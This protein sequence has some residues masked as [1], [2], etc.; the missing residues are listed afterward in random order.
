MNY[1]LRIDGVLGDSLDKDHKGW[2]AIDSLALDALLDGSGRFG[3]LSSVQFG[4]ASM[5]L[6]TA[7]QPALQNGTLLDAVTL[8]MVSTDG[9]RL[10]QIRL[11]DV[12][13][14]GLSSA[15]QNGDPGRLGVTLDART[16]S[17]IDYGLNAQG[18]AVRDAEFGWDA[19]LLRPVD[20]DTVDL[21]SGG[22]QL[23]S[24]GA[25]TQ[26]FVR[27][28]GVSGNA[29]HKAFS[30]WF[31][32]TGFDGPI[33]GGPGAQPDGAPL[34]LQLALGVGLAPILTRLAGGQELAAV[35]IH[36]INSLGT[37]VHEIRLNDV[38]ITGMDGL[39]ASGPE[40]RLQLDYGQVGQRFTGVDGKGLPLTPVSF[41]WDR[42]TE[43]AVNFAEL[44]EAVATASPS[45]MG[46]LGS[47]YFVRFNDLGGDSVDAKHKGWFD[48][49]DFDLS[50]VVPTLLSKGNLVANGKGMDFSPLTLDL[51]LGP[52]LATLLARAGDTG[53][54]GNLE[55][56]GIQ[57]LSGGGTLTPFTLR[58][59]GVSL[60][61]ADVGGP[62]A[63]ES[64]VLD[65]QQIGLIQRGYSAAGTLNTTNS[66]GWDFAQN[67]SIDATAVGTPTQGTA[68]PGDTGRLNT[69]YLRIDGIGGP[70]VDAD[71][72]GWFEL[73]DLDLRFERT[74]GG[75]PM[76]PGELQL[77]F[78]AGT[79]LPL[80]LSQ[81]T[82]GKSV[83]AVE[84]EGV[85]NGASGPV[86]LQQIR[87]Q[88]VLFSSVGE[89]SGNQ[90][91]FSL[92]YE[93]ISLDEDWLDGRG[94]VV[95]GTVYSYDLVNEKAG[96][97]ALPAASSGV[98]QY[99]HP[100]TMDHY[101]FIDGIDGGVRSKGLEGAFQLGDFALDLQ[102]LVSLGAGGATSGKPAF[103][104]LSLN[105]DLSQGLAPL[106]AQ[107]FG[108]GAPLGAARV[109]GVAHTSTASQTLYE[110]R[111]NQVTVQHLNERSD[112]FGDGLDLGF[113]SLGLSTWGLDA[114]G[115]RTAATTFGWDTVKNTELPFAALSQP[116]AP[117]LGALAGGGSR[118]FLKIDGVYGNVT[119][120]GHLGWFE[121][122]GFS[123][124]TDL[125]KG[126]PALGDVDLQLQAGSDF[127]ALLAPLLMGR[128]LDAVQIHGVR[129]LQLDGT[130]E[131][132]L[133]WRFNGVQFTHI[134]QSGTSGD[135]A[136]QTALSLNA[137]RFGVVALRYDNAGKPV[138][139]PLLF[140]YDSAA[141]QGVDPRN[142]ATPVIGTGVPFTAPVDS[143]TTPNATTENAV[144][145]SR[146][147]LDMSSAAAE[148]FELRTNP[149]NLFA[150]NATTGVVTVAGQIGAHL[151][152]QT[153]TLSI[154][155]IT[156]EGVVKTS[157]FGVFVGDVP[158]QTFFGGAG[159]DTQ[160]GGDL[161][162]LF[163]GGLG[164]DSFT[165]GS[166]NDSL[167]GTAG[168]DRL[169]GDAGDDLLDGG[170]GIDTAVF[171][172]TQS[173]TVSL[174]IAGPQDTGHGMDQLV[175]IENIVSAGSGDD[176]LTGNQLANTINAGA[177]NDTLVGG[178]GND[179]LLGGNGNDLLRG[180]AGNDT[181]DGG[182][183][184]D[185]AVYATDTAGVQVSLL[186]SG[187]EQFISSTQGLDTL[188]GIEHLTSG[189][190]HDRLTGNELD[191]QLSGGN[192]NDTLEGGAGNDTLIGGAGLD[193]AV[194]TGNAAVTVNLSIL[195]AQNTGH[196]MDTL[197]SIENLRS[198]NGND[199]LTGNGAANTI[200]AGVGSDT[201]NGGLG[202][203]VLWGEG[204]D[205]RLN[206]G[207]GND[208]LIGG[209]GRDTLV[210]GAG[211][212]LFRYLQA[213][214]IGLSGE[215]IAD[216]Q[217]GLDQIDLT[218]LGLS[219][220]VAS[221]SGTAGE[222]R[223]SAPL[224][225]QWLLQGDLNGD[226]VADFQL[227][228]LGV[229]L[230][231]AGDILI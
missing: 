162:D 195:V 117:V 189:S 192:G 92:A 75:G 23:L 21:A 52:A 171:V 223:L 218:A 35:Q 214:E 212:D 199:S 107:Q 226:A 188:I 209:L 160:A 29:T 123:L 68:A 12:S 136:P 40:Q 105:L 200:E 187:T 74:P 11:D 206:G 77:V 172:G 170:A 120:K 16:I 80:L 150:I 128:T 22:T 2:F 141:A 211:N 176:R 56:E 207:D 8:E 28:D 142:L 65:F 98:Q 81:L 231:S 58:L 87:L 33:P 138:N 108:G 198:G 96:S 37:L 230:V 61:Q 112:L 161:A 78:D 14:G 24:G 148:R 13:V 60:I 156:P 104:T 190:G 4:T 83:A 90:E 64:L 93:A 89:G 97:T 146:I 140:G 1:Y 43:R 178:A 42:E 167:Y 110:L 166:G 124:P 225:G 134:G 51:D 118:F 101:L 196:G 70:S 46:G 26:Y 122:D 109:L 219:A 48:L 63:P 175:G 180:D 91:R 174:A 131:L 88:D 168:N 44:Q 194:F 165:G 164:N 99:G 45:A 125:S 3:D 210:G 127:A 32:L 182:N 114:S 73:S 49:P 201:V 221:F 229:S 85:T 220:V 39:G 159:A 103:S 7:L 224:A 84:I 15:W 57:L 147:G 132:V 185:T 186:L 151:V 38:F 153:L 213:D 217:T 173:T 71:H 111:L 113:D 227:Q 82:S 145:G 27:F 203:D 177:G 50:A 135:A 152:G 76:D 158:G 155:A 102:S 72:K 54:I 86:T 59:G 25:G 193:T 6:L 62:G 10:Q 19:A 126:A 94:Q 184:Q 149:E 79:A 36:G 100:E 20:A 55:I 208:T 197:Q 202:A 154:D 115:K 30:G 183:G 204:G 67:K 130:P 143:D 18:Q 69:Y 144:L 169:Q 47:Q 9:Q 31:E 137:D 119:E 179:R 228:V 191:N 139:D 222:L 121:L 216:F 181:L 205:D 66:F 133:D 53:Q 5:Q 41:G 34:D 129:D 157:T 163:Q 116:A 215:R 17:V 106:L 95:Q